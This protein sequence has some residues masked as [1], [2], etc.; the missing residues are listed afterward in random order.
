MKLAYANARFR[1]DSHDGANAHVRQFVQ[2][3]LKIRRTLVVPNGSDPELYKPGV[4]PVRRMLN[5][6]DQ[7][8]VLWIGSAYV[9]WHN[10]KLLSDAANIIFDRGNP[11]NI[12]FHLL[13]QG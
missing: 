1:S 9:A 13:G 6:Q 2:N 7:F 8:N 11:H 4:P 10:F 5:T 12:V 3:N